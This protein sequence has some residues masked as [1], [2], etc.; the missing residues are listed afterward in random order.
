MLWTKAVCPDVCCRPGTMQPQV[1]GGV[2]AGNSQ[3]SAEAVL[4]SQSQLRK[5]VAEVL[6]GEVFRSNVDERLC[7]ASCLTLVL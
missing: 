4:E 7:A 1:L 2:S 5:P 6:A 3:R